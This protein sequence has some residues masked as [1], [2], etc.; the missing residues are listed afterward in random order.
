MYKDNEKN[1]KLSMGKFVAEGGIFKSQASKD[2]LK[3]K[4]VARIAQTE[5]DI[6][7]WDLIKK[8]L[9]VY[10]AEIAI[11]EFRN[12]KNLKYITAMQKFAFDELE[13]SKRQR[14]CWNDFGRMTDKTEARHETVA[15]LKALVSR[16]DTN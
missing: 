2:K 4:I 6:T 11:P 7:N 10:L 13:N 5:R 1:M 16:P 9:I 8:M 3:D 15:D 12:S 14:E